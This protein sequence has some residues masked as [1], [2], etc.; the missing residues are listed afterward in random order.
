MT[1]EDNARRI[2]ALEADIKT[3][4]LTA[5]CKEKDGRVMD[6][7]DRLHD[8]TKDLSEAIKEVQ[9]ARAGDKR[10]S[11]ATL[12]GVIVTAVFALLGLV[13]NHLSKS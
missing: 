4:V 9:A 2:A 7:V 11:N 8:T 12:V 1:V 13:L 10:R 5:V 6:A 3:R